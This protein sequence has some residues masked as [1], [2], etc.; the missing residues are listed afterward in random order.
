MMLLHFRNCGKSG[1]NQSKAEME[2]GTKEI[3]ED[4]VAKAAE[5]V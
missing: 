3:R 2:I 4:L 5:V 1:R